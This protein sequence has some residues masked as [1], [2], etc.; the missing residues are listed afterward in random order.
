MSDVE[1]TAKD[2]ILL[3][4]GWYNR[5]MYL[6]V[7]DALKEYYWERFSED[8]DPDESLLLDALLWPSLEYVLTQY[9]DRIK[10][11]LISCEKERINIW[12][13]EK[14]HN[15]IYQIQMCYRIMDFFKTLPMRGDKL[16]EINVDNWFENKNK[17]NISENE[18]RLKKPIIKERRDGNAKKE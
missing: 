9:P 14:V 13:G 7:L 18:R 15:D 5:K 1:K 4:K 6:T 8:Y 10:H 3:V 17:L 16:Q 2:V 11:F 12:Y